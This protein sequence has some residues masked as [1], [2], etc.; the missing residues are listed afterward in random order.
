MSRLASSQQCEGS[1]STNQINRLE[2]I[3]HVIN[4]IDAEKALDKVECNHDQKLGI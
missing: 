1:I 3:S 4:S 2:D